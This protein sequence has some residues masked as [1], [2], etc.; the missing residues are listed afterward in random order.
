[1][2]ASENTTTTPKTCSYPGCGQPVKPAGET[3]RPSEYCDNSKHTKV[4][5]WRERKRQQAEQAGTS[6]AASTDLPV[7]HA[8]VTAPELLRSLRVEADR[9]AG[10]VAQLGDA[11]G[12]LTDPIAVEAELEAVRAD[13]AQRATTAEARAAAAERRAAEADRL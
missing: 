8:R 10:I 12:T 13:A 4:S 9:L 3:G 7:S 11:A 2:M 1:M 6:T 5:A